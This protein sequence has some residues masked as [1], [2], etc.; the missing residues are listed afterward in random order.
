VYRRREAEETVT[1]YLGDLCGYIKGDE[2]REVTL[3][4]IE[5]E[6]HWK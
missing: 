1:K 3:A 6:L 4:K 2:R 5:N